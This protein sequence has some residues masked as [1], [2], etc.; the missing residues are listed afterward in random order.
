[1]CKMTENLTKCQKTPIV[2]VAIDMAI[3]GKKRKNAKER[4]QKRTAPTS[5]QRGLS[6]T[7]LAE[8][9]GFEPSRRFPDLRP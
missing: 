3:D 4:R 8:K 6:D 7:V 1:M 9:E 2:Q 5:P